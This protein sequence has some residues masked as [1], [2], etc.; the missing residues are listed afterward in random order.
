MCRLQA[1]TAKDADAYVRLRN[2]GQVVGAVTDCKCEAGRCNGERGSG[3]AYGADDES[4]LGGRGAAADYQVDI[5]DY[6][7]E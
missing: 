4:L 5:W 7:E 3:F 2:Y 6:S 1:F